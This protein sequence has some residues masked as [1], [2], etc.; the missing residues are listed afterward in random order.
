MWE[1][2]LCDL[3]FINQPTVQAPLPEVVKSC[4]ATKCWVVPWGVQLLKRRVPSL[5]QCLLPTDSELVLSAWSYLWGLLFSHRC[6][7]LRGVHWF[8][9]WVLGL[10]RINA[11]LLARL[12]EQNFCLIHLAD[13]RLS[14]VVS[15]AVG[16]RKGGFWASGDAVP[17]F[18][19]G[20]RSLECLL[21]G[22]PGA[23]FPRK[24]CSLQRGLG[25]GM[26]APCCVL[27]LP[28]FGLSGHHFLGMA[29]CPHTEWWVPGADN[30]SVVDFE[31][32]KF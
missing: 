27:L 4:I 8:H 31:A 20:L 1:S 5:G 18:S 21:G 30:C 19:W 29:S 16:K 13:P 25:W 17:P 24:F 26:L 7:P 15:K 28:N 11:P 10:H 12:E 22:L 6:C 2:G 23:R 14:C 32:I 9:F 3:Q